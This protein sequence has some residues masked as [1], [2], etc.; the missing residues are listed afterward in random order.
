MAK[1]GDD[2]S[3]SSGFSSDEED[4]TL[5]VSSVGGGPPPSRFDAAIDIQMDEEPTASLPDLEWQTV[6]ANSVGCMPPCCVDLARPLLEA[7]PP[8]HQYMKYTEAISHLLEHCPVEEGDES[9]INRYRALR[10]CVFAQFH[11][12]FPIGWKNFSQWIDDTDAV[13][14][15]RK[16]FEVA[17]KDYWSVPLTLKYLRFLQGK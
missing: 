1:P 9:V 2:D 15:Q 11:R 6:L 7:S 3:S 10:S 16:L 5:A 13:E 4:E 12:A 14:Y 8:S 17:P